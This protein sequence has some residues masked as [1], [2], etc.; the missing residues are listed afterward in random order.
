MAKINPQ[1]PRVPLWPWGGP[2]SV[3]ERLVDPS[4]LDRKKKSGRKPDPKNPALPSAELLDFIG[5]GHTSEELRLPLPP[6]PRGH[7]ADLEAF[8]DRPHLGSAL[9]R[10]GEDQ[11]RALEKG[12]DRLNASADRL[13]RLRALIGREQ[14]MLAM[15]AQLNDDVEEIQRRMREEQREKGY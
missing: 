10:A 9:M 4:Q 15:V 2:K 14:Q 1:P 7:D 8:N 3:R 6:N 5:P 13:D 11:T 12:L